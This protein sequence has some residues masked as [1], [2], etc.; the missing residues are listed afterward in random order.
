M[1]LVSLVYVSRAAE[2]FSDEQLRDLLAVARDR[3]KE[4]NV[5]G[6]LLYRD[7]FFI[8]A[9]EGEDQQVEALYEKIKQDPRH[10]SVYRVYKEKIKN[11]VFPDW[12]MGFNKVGDEDLKQ[13]D[14]YT[15]FLTRPDPNFFVGNPD[16]AKVLLT[17]FRRGLTF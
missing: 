12:S 14:G 9:L 4:L 8:Q 16:R 15:T 1:A 11:R 3:N 10:R 5:T 2:A 13:L 7:G 17:A 6:M